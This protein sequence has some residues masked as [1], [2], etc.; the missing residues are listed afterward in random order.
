MPDA[1]DELC[2]RWE[3]WSKAMAK[4]AEVGGELPQPPVPRRHDRGTTQALLRV[5]E[6]SA[7]AA[8]ALAR[9][10]MGLRRSGGA[11]R[12]TTTKRGDA[13]PATAEVERL[14]STLRDL[15]TRLKESQVR[16]FKEVEDALWVASQA[17]TK[18]QE[19]TAV[20]RQLLGAQGDASAAVAAAGAGGAGGGGRG[21][22]K[23]HDASVG[24]AL[25]MN[26]GTLTPT[27]GGK[28][29]AAAARPRQGGLLLSAD[30]AGNDGTID[31]EEFVRA[32]RAGIFTEGP[33]ATL[34]TPAL[35]GR[36]QDAGGYANGYA[37][38]RQRLQDGATR[39]EDE[40][41]EFGR[42]LNPSTGEQ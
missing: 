14:K 38:A 40:V 17:E 25:Y 9:A 31:R 36:A 26:T 4:A 30:E 12:G 29:A 3:E 22:P 23:G 10:I 11:I 33:P 28:G 21:G 37:D 5:M 16:R 15:E 27:A 13:D 2:T 7:Y 42:A 8:G 18:Q 24:L 41:E 39:W 19:M 20:L 1:T 34:A 6:A 32:Y 35:R